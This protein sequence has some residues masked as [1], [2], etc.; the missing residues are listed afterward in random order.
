[1]ADTKNRYS[2][3]YNPLEDPEYRKLTERLETARQQKPA[4]QGQY[5]TQAQAL[6]DRLQN[7]QAFRYDIDT[8][9]LYRQ[10]RDRYTALGNRAMEDTMGRAQAMTGGYANSY[11]QTAGQ[12]AYTSYLEKLN[13]TVPELYDRALERY[14]QGYSDLED[15]Y[16]LAREQG[17]QEY[18]RHQDALDSY[19]KEVSALQSQA[20]Q[21]YQRG[22]QQYLD[23]YKMA[24]DAYTR[25]AAL[26]K[27]GYTP[28][29]EE[30]RQAGMTEAQAK[31]L[32][33]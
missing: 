27:K 25:L 14:R 22:Y 15:Q 16:Q 30:L 9:A 28:P 10:Y 17:Q 26:I 8:D 33:K 2:A 31:A 5:D 24:S 6:Y 20:D 29:P 3:G 13:Q 19:R 11:A 4:Y 18:S 12:Q 23:G 32:R 7:R 1:M 21:A